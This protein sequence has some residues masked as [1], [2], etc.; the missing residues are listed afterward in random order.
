[1]EK[2]KK[3]IKDYVFKDNL[4]IYFLLLTTLL[5]IS[6]TYSNNVSYNDL[7]KIKGIYYKKETRW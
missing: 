5:I 6:Q 3:I 4:V 2:Q 7:V 1:M